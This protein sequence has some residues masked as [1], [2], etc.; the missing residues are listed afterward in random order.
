MHEMQKTSRNKDTETNQDEQRRTNGER[1]MPKMRN[2]RLQNGRPQINMKRTIITSDEFVYDVLN[3][4]VHHN[5][6][7]INKKDLAKSRALK[8]IV[9][10][11]HDTFSIEENVD[12]ITLKKI[13]KL[14]AN[15]KFLKKPG[16]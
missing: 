15:I 4:M 12:Y 7:I 3:N 14:D 5:E 8:H 1:S 6:I 2:N 11:V 16:Y 9:S 13:K 10:R